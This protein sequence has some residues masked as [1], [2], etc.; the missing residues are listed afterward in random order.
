MN[1]VS[2]TGRLTKDVELRYTQSGMAT[3][4]LNVAVDRKLSKDK[5]AE[6]QAKGE[7]TTDF[8]SCVAFGKTAE[9]IATYLGKGRKILIEGRIQTGSYDKDGHKVYTTDVI[10]DQFEFIDSG[11][12]QAPTFNAGDFQAIE[13]DE[14]CPF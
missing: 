11:D 2:I 10:V 7:P 5:K 13:D 6:L 8:I 12:K 1:H 4:R 14:D 9:T 3:T